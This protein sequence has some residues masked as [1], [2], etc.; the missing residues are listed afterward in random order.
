[1]PE[2]EITPTMIG[3]LVAWAFPVLERVSRSLF[4]SKI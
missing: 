1:M 3:A 2:I 4:G